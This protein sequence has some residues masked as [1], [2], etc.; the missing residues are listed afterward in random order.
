MM[1]TAT[2][3][4]DTQIAPA[5]A[6]LKAM[7]NESRLRILCLLMAGERSVTQI[8]R[9]MA[10]SQSALSQHLAVLRQERLVNTR[11]SSQVIYYSL[12]GHVAERLIATLA[13][14]DLGQR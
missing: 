6:I 13:E 10:L 8:N 12:N 5:T 1:M 2:L 3:L 11:R 4:D 7:A 14:L 9:D